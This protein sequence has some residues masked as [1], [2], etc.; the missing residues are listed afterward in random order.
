MQG[1]ALNSQ[2]QEKGAGGRPLGSKA[3]PGYFL[4]LG[5][6][7]G[8]RSVWGSLGTQ[9]GPPSIQELG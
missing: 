4:L 2:P 6:E 8:S 7:G 5:V 1:L 9:E 3:G